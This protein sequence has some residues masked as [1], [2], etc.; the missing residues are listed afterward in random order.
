VGGAAIKKDNNMLIMGKI[1]RFLTT[2]DMPA[3]K[4]GRLS[5]GDP[6]L[7]F[8]M[9]NGRRVRGNM[10]RRVETFITAYK[11]HRAAFKKELSQ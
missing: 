5:A 7:V 3:T 2:Y 6:R 10:A 11:D 9:R 8:D 4:F 1:E